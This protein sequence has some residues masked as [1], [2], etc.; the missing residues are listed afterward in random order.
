M[1]AQSYDWPLLNTVMSENERLSDELKTRQQILRNKMI[2]LAVRG[3]IVTATV[4]IC[5]RMP[6]PS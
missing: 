6:A 4:I 1:N 3:A 5:R 2:S